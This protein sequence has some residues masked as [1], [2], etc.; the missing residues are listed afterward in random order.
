MATVRCAASHGRLGKVGICGIV[1][2]D[3][4]GLPIGR[5][6]LGGGWEGDISGIDG[7]GTLA[8]PFVQKKISLCYAMLYY[9]MLCYT[10]LCYA[11]RPQHLWTGLEMMLR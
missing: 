1:R 3:N 6:D 4:T 8:Y 2:E 9:A 11:A 7:M 5:M 10:M